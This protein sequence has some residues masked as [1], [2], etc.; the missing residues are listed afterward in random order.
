MCNVSICLNSNLFK[1]ILSNL[2]SFRQQP[3][4]YLDHD[5][6]YN[7]RRSKA[8]LKV[9]TNNF[10]LFRDRPNLFHVYTELIIHITN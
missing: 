4:P 6:E 5:G 2:Y 3:K 8:F 1:F 9:N 10:L 7:F